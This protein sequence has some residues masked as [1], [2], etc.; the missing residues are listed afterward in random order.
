M[1]SKAF[2]CVT[3]RVFFPVLATWLASASVATLF[4]CS[5]SAKS[6]APSTAPVDAAEASQDEA[7][8]RDAAPDARACTP[9]A[10]NRVPRWTPPTPFHQGVCT[11]AQVTAFLTACESAGRE[12]CKAFVAANPACAACA[13]N[14]EQSSVWGPLVVDDTESYA[15]LNRA[16]CVANRIGDTSASGCGAAEGR[17]D[18]CT[19]NACRGCLP[20]ASP[21]ADEL[22]ACTLAAADG[23]ECRKERIDYRQKCSFYYDA[24]DPESPGEFCIRQFTRLQYIRLWCTGAAD[25]GA[26]AGDGG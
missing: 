22:G 1:Q 19:R 24:S 14:L 8:S 11:D 18:D 4:S 12:A 15:F 13:L 7:N 6:D 3:R 26:E 2:A 5:E 16:G 21:S 17:L 23:E 9:Q 20:L 25:G 10:P